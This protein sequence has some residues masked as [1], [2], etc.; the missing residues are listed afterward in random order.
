M[1]E[2]KGSRFVVCCQN[3]KWSQATNLI[4]SEPRAVPSFLTWY[5]AAFPSRQSPGSLAAAS[6]QVVTLIH[7][8]PMRDALTA[9]G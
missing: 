7:P 1:I 8:Q 5:F 6:A 9:D 4:D 3:L 2:M